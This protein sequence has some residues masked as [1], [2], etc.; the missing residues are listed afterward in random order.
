VRCSTSPRRRRSRKE[1]LPQRPTCRRKPSPARAPSAWPNRPAR[2]K[3][4]C[5]RAGAAAR[6][7]S[8][9][10]RAAAAPLRRGAPPRLLEPLRRDRARRPEALR[11]QRYA[12]LLEQPPVIDDLVGPR[13]VGRIALAPLVEAPCRLPYRGLI[14]RVLRCAP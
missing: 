9:R 13:P 8:L 1:R 14:L 6:T 4:R 11:E 5:G 10:G 2:P 7:G 12:K 3:A